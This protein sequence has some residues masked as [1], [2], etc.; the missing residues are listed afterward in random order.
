MTELVI[1]AAALLVIGGGV[2]LSTR[3]GPS[4]SA[5]VPKATKPDGIDPWSLDWLFGRDAVVPSF[6]QEPPSRPAPQPDT[7]FVPGGGVLVPD[8]PAPDPWAA[9]K[10]LPRDVDILART[11]W[12]EARG[13][14]KAGQEAV[15]SVI[16]NRVADRRWPSTAADVC[17]QPWQFSMWNEGEPNRAKALAVN[18]QNIIFRQCVDI[19]K[20]AVAGQLPDRTRGANH[21]HTKAVDPTWNR[22][23]RQ[24]ATIGAHR[25]FVG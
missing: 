17:L 12:G 2:Y 19:A 9:Y 18:Y 8:A 24:T 3:P 25:F 10:D 23:M 13:E 6:D 14:S 22:N 1:A 16:M 20:L 15:A 4:R 21:Y 7:G 5:P 11:L